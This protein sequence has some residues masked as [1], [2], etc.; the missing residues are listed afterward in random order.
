MQ[1]MLQQSQ[2]SALEI[3]SQLEYTTEEI[4]TLEA[5]KDQVSIMT[6]KKIVDRLLSLCS[7]LVDFQ[8]ST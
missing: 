2:M 6:R 3:Q 8:T 7:I 1:K 4:S 5:S